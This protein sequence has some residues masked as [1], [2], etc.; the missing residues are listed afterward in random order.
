[1]L[2]L[3]LS[4]KTLYWSSCCSGIGLAASLQHQDAGL[5]PAQHS[6][7]KD[8]ASPSCGRGYKYGS[9][10][11]PGSGTPYASGWPKK[12]KKIKTNQ[13]KKYYAN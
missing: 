13:K 10:L 12:K 5:I 1:M 3:E 6:G 11:I 8:L 2:Q 9:D 4:F 7:I